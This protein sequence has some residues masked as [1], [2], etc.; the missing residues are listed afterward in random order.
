M[1]KKDNN[2]SNEIRISQYFTYVGP[3]IIFLGMIRLMCF[4]NA[5]GI[6]ITNY[7]DFSEVITSFF[8]ILAFI[9]VGFVATSLNYFLTMN[10]EGIDLANK[11]RR[12]LLEEKSTWRI[13]V[14]YVKYLKSLLFLSIT[15]IVGCFIGH[16][17]FIEV[18]YFNIFVISL[19]LFAIIIFLIM[20]I[21]IERKHSHFE[22]SIHRR[23]FISVVLYS[24]LLIGAVSYYSLY[25]ALCIKKYKSTIGTIVILDNDKSIISDSTNY[26]IGNTRNYLFIHHE[27]QNITDVIPISRV[28]Q[29]T[30]TNGKAS[31]V[32]IFSANQSVFQ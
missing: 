12:E 14:L 10:K 2:S 22:S 23:R 18:T 3:F 9:V 31:H 1:S 25:Q 30:V 4:Y 17:F 11:N 7:L 26:Y 21:E 28:K 16:H 20:S 32:N 13:W 27:K 6:S 24:F 19:I 5:F 15:I 29:I 8:D